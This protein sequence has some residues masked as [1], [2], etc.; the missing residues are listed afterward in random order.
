MVKTYTFMSAM[1]LH[2]PINFPALLLYSKTMLMNLHISSGASIFTHALPPHASLVPFE[3][4]YADK[5][6]TSSLVNPNR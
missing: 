4:L 3:K 1:H 6:A 2:L 5:V